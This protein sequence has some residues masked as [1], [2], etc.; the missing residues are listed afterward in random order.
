MRRFTQLFTEL[1]R[2][3]RSGE[4]LAALERYFREA[5]AADA[6]WGLHFLAGRKIKRLAPRSALRGLIEQLTG[7]PS[8]LVGESYEAVGDLAETLALLVPDSPVYDFDVPL[9]Q[10]VQQRLLP[11][12]T[13]DEDSQ[14][15]V[16]A[17]TWREL[18]A[19]QRFV[20][21]KLITG[22]F[23]VGVAQTMIVKALAAAAD[24]P[25]AIMAQRF[26]GNWEPSAE[27]FSSLMTGANADGDLASQGQP[28]PFFLGYPLEIPVA[29]LGEPR[30]WIAEWKYDGIRAQV[31]R[32]DGHIMIWSRGEE[33]ITG[34]FPEI[35]QAAMT[36]PKDV[37]LDGE[38]LAWEHDRPLLFTV[39]QR[40]I[41]RVQVEPSL[42][43]EVPVRFIAFDLLELDGADWREQP[44][45]ERHEQLR[46]LSSATAQSSDIVVAPSVAFQSWDELTALLAG[47]RERGVEGVMLK[48]IDGT[49]RIGRRR[50][51]WWKW[52]IDPLLLD[53]V[54][55]YA[56]AGSG[57]R[58]GLF[59]DYTFGVWSGPDKNRELVPVAKAYSGLTDAEIK[60]VDRFIRNNTLQR[61]GP[62]RIVKPELVFELAFQ[63]VQESSRHKAG[64]AVRFPR[65]NRWRKDKIAR[66]ADTIETLRAMVALDGGPT[67]SKGPPE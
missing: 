52:K 28:Y 40:R 53:A 58:S 22:N 18:D 57:R 31:I 29:E 65:M 17:R 23:R 26:S 50:G 20:F 2:T 3:K 55:I 49:Y 1:D 60:D 13:L 24:V 45:H 12:K 61:H 6:A 25:V 34:A 44:L 63:G 30:D 9:H 27:S 37:V 67:A 64:L 47:V 48:R 54:L 39:L 19:D 11:M 16:I 14:R 21:N 7:L 43:P 66:E 41:N 33:L 36:L 4:K 8:W 15:E 42:F 32:R 35:A 5:P 51:D 59:T 46:S 10:I 56:Q 38:I 62:V